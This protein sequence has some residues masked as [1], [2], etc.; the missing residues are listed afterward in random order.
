MEDDLNICQFCLVAQPQLFIQI[1][2]NQEINPFPIGYIG[3]LLIHLL[4]G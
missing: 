1:N 3:N 2:Y 4:S